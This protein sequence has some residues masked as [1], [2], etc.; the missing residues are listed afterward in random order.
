MNLLQK[1]FNGDQ[2]AMAL[3][4]AYEIMYYAYPQDVYALN[5]IA[6]HLLSP[7]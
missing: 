4:A 3:Y 1:A 2:E 5:C 7:V 6:Y